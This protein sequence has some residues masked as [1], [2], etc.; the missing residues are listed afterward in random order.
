MGFVIYKKR[1]NNNKKLR[2]GDDPIAFTNPIYRGRIEN[3]NIDGT[4]ETFEENPELYQ[5]TIP[6]SNG[7]KQ[8]DPTD[9][10]IECVPDNDGDDGDDV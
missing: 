9:E 10:Y 1:K 8:Y 2:S 4:D 6:G 3:E 7:S 5:D